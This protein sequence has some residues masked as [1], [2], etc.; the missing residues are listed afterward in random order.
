MTEY[1]IPVGISRC[2]LG[3]EVRYNGGH[4]LS[5]YCRDHL[6]NHFEFVDRCPEVEIGMG[7]P[8]E[9]VRLIEFGTKNGFAVGL[10]SRV[11]EAISIP[12]IA[13]GGVGNLQHLA[14]GV[15]EGKAD[16]VLAASIFHYGEYTVGQAKEFMA[17]QGIEMRL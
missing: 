11:S 17:K 3:E 9:P 15:T 6:G 16:A 1:K 4:K 5:R 10:C 2:L 7:I 8:R 13:S 14:D 12:V